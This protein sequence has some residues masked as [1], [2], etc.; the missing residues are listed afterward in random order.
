MIKELHFGSNSVVVFENEM[1]VASAVT[2]F[3]AS[4][5]RSVL[6]SRDDYRI[7]ISG[8]S[9]PK[10]YF[11]LLAE[12][13]FADEIGWNKF[14]VFFVDERYVPHSHADSNYKMARDWLFEK[15]KLD[16]SN[17]HPIPTDCDDINDCVKK[18]TN[19]LNISSDI[20]KLPPFDLIILG[21]GDDGHT[22]SLFPDTAA[23]SERNAAVTSVYVE[24]LDSWRISLTYPVLDAARQLLVPV[25]GKQKAAVLAEVMSGNQNYPIGRIKN[26]SGLL[27]YI[28]V[29][30]ASE[31]PV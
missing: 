4:H 14:Q 9:T 2:N 11:S 24:K 3:I 10:L 28:D 19:E 23:L 8:G 27:W 16:K 1:D 6:S 5:S 26:P 18:Y 17:L 22:A 15:I 31:L 7:A 12:K 13:P 29:N 20:G 25:C 21:M 30:A